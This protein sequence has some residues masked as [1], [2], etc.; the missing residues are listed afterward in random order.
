MSAK[1]LNEL[2]DLAGRVISVSSDLGDC[3]LTTQS[4]RPAELIE[5]VKSPSETSRWKDR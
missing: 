3:R 2:V 1:S 4:N 5:D